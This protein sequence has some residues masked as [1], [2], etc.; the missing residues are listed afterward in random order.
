MRTTMFDQEF[1]VKLQAE[2]KL[3]ARLHEQ[4]ILPHQVDWLTSLIGR[5]PWQVLL[6]ASGLT[7]VVVEA[8]RYV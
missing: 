6:V 8:S 1:L 3:Q 2:A 4:R 7:A 5:Y